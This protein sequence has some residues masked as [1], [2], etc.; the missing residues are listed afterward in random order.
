MQA[1]RSLQ[2]LRRH[3]LTMATMNDTAFSTSTSKTT[4]AVVTATAL[5]TGEPDSPKS[6]K[7]K[8]WFGDLVI[9]AALAGMIGSNLEESPV[10]KRPQ[11]I[12]DCYKH[13]SA[14]AAA[15]AET[16]AMPGVYAKGKT[17]GL[18]KEH[19]PV[20][21]DW[22]GDLLC[23]AAY[24]RIKSALEGLAAFD[25]ALQRC[26][27]SMPDQIELLVVNSTDRYIRSRRLGQDGTILPSKDPFTTEYAFGRKKA[28]TVQ[29]TVPAGYILQQ[30]NGAELMTGMAREIAHS[31]ANHRAEEQSC[32]ALLWMIGGCIVRLAFT[33]RIGLW[34][35]IAANCLWHIV[36]RWGVPVWLH[37]QQVYDAD[38]VAATVVTASGAD[39][40]S[41]L[42]AM[43]RAYYADVFTSEGAALQQRQKQDIQWH[44]SR[45]QSLL[46]RSH[47]PK[48]A[49]NDSTGLQ[50]V[51][52][53][54]AAEI[55][56]APPHVTETYKEIMVALEGRIA[57]E[58]CLLRNPFGV[59]TDIG[60]HWLD[61]IAR[62]DKMLK[63]STAP[64]STSYA[65]TASEYADR[66]DPLDSMS[67]VTGYI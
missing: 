54:A 19:F 2:S 14:A 43:Q 53:A 57:D 29:I 44:L 4:A 24:Y 11:L 64:S 5:S 61:R 13:K 32:K 20:Q 46:H 41:S 56:S 33:G 67:N 10:T 48:H 21:F 47:I 26:L 52:D 40:S 8:Y 55:N 31:L 23:S 27:A 18:I 16:A 15:A 30:Q 62:V 3:W 39:S 42:T 17:S 7:T 36:S 60:P 51:I 49:V 34:R 59:W 50:Q 45:L 35:V 38:A 58:L 12:F 28:S 22:P 65:S 9:G 6:A 1:V 63:S 66:S 25:T 37:Q